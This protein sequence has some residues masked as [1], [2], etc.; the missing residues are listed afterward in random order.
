VK[1]IL[2]LDGGGIRGLMTARVLQEI[3]I[4]LPNP[5]N[6]DLSKQNIIIDH[7]DLI[8]G[9]STGAILAAGLSLGIPLSAIVNLYSLRGR[10]I[11]R[12]AVS[13][14]SSRLGRAFT[15]GI[16]HPKHSDKGLEEELKAVFG[17]SRLGDVKI[18]LLL[19]VFDAQEHEPII[20][21]SRS[22]DW[23]EDK[24]L[25]LWELVKS[26][27]SAPTYFPAH[28][29]K[30]RDYE[31][32]HAMIDGGVFAN[33]PTMV[34][35]SEAFASS[36]ISGDE[37]V[38]CVSVGTSELERQGLSI[39][40][41]REMGAIEWALPLLSILMGGA[42]RHVHSLA[43]RILSRGGKSADNYLRFQMI[44]D[45]DIPMDEA[46]DEDIEVMN[47][48]I[49]NYVDSFPDDEGIRKLHEKSGYEFGTNL[50]ALLTHF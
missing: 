32:P 19:Q 14:W 11:F 22:P 5:G 1:K 36:L 27:S 42:S 35:L 40:E 50:K 28:P 46:L 12:P 29:L 20:F 13:R 37:E 45:E 38:L 17:D 10:R 25:L 31:E 4:N 6:V 30:Y 16:S 34:A 21:K 18:P 23:E 26:S 41:A 24:A 33:N 9:T 47:S 48:V 7:F 3:E 49:A 15:Q 44:T 8:A 2:A 43:K 39:D